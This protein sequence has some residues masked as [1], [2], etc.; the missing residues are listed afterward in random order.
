MNAATGEDG[1]AYRIASSLGTPKS[2]GKWWMTTCPCHDDKKQ[3]LAVCDGDK[4]GLSLHCHAGCDPKIIFRHLVS[5]GLIK[6]NTSSDQPPAKFKRVEAIYSYYDENGKLIH[7]TVRYHPKTFAQ[8]RPDPKN[9]GAYIWTLSGVRRCLYKLN[10]VL[11]HPL[12]QPIL[13]VEGEKDVETARALGFVATTKAEGGKSKWQP[14]Y[15]EWLKKRLVYIIP[16]NDATG[17]ASAKNVAECLRE[18][19]CIVHMLYLPQGSKDLTAWVEN[20]DGNREKLLAFMEQSKIVTTEKQENTVILRPGGGKNLH[21]PWY[22]HLWSSYIHAA[23]E[24]G[25]VGE[26]LNIARNAQIP[27]VYES[28]W[29]GVFSLNEMDD[30]IFITKPN[31]YLHGKSDR[32]IRQVD[33]FSY[34]GWLHDHGMYKLSIDSVR[35]AIQLEA[36]NHTYHPVRKYLEG[37]PAWDG[38]NRVE[39]V[40]SQY[41]GAEDNAYVRACSKMLFLTLIARPMSPGCLARQIVVLESNEDRGKSSFVRMLSPNDEWVLE[42]KIDP[43]DEKR[44]PA[45][46]SRS[47]IIELPELASFRTDE[48]VEIIKAFIS[49]RFE[50]YIPMYGRFEIQKPRSFVLVGT[51]NGK[52]YLPPNSENTRFFPVP[53]LCDGRKNVDVKGFEKARDQ[54]YAEAMKRWKSGEQYWIDQD[55]ISSIASYMRHSRQNTDPWFDIIEM[56]VKDKNII[57]SQDIVGELLNLPRE[58]QNAMA[59]RRIASIMDQLGYSRERKRREAFDNPAWAYIK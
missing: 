56:Y 20:A 27:L 9:H 19:Q 28:S 29:Q 47:W 43:R 31:K 53:L 37:L 38:I 42:N 12:D 21:I 59:S 33:E 57:W 30:T 25:R 2:S 8:R 1:F 34:Q 7:E 45:I 50:R 3:S 32:P 23:G 4:G 48:E 49:R 51:V 17:E 39:N 16:D 54:V 6:A 58:R 41:G 11:A 24:E 52:N 26:P 46:I 22:K 13:W 15:S 55:D 36:Q 35:A 14:Q 40:L 44:T 18:A 5:I 10:E